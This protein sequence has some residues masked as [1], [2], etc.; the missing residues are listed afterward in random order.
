M[1]RPRHEKISR[2][3]FDQMKKIAVFASLS[4]EVSRFL[5]EFVP[6]YWSHDIV[7]CDPENEA[8]WGKAC[9]LPFRNMVGR[10]PEEMLIY[11]SK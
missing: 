11:A 10:V 3:G 7:V 4:S 2:Y 1:T 6:P 5:R 9:G 8:T